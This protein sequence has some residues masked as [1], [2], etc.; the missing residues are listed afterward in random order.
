MSLDPESIDRLRKLGREL[1]TELPKQKIISKKNTN[2]KL[3]P[4]EIE[5]D[6]NQLFHELIKASNDGN[7]PS[8]LL[9]R[10]KELEEK[11]GNNTKGNNNEMQSTKPSNK[12]IS[13]N[14]KPNNKND[15]LYT[16]FTQLLLEEEL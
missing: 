6:P 4:I 12:S 8:H 5:E 11:N 2:T 3:H 9:K 15:A 1:P 16:L 10:L 7:V 13:K 14:S